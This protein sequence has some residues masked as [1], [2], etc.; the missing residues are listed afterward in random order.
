MCLVLFPSSP[1]G[2][3]RGLV[4]SH[5]QATH[6]VC[7]AGLL[8][9]RAL[10]L[11]RVSPASRREPLVFPIMFSLVVFPFSHTWLHWAQTRVIEH[12]ASSLPRALSDLRQGVAA[13][14]LQAEDAAYDARVAF[15]ART[16]EQ[17]GTVAAGFPKLTRP[18]FGAGV[19][20]TGDR[21]RLKSVWCRALRSPSASAQSHHPGVSGDRCAG[22]Q[23]ARVAERCLWPLWEYKLSGGA[24]LAPHR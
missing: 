15:M 9:N 21:T 17:V 13:T 4:R 22:W 1:R 2:S 24:L 6:M 5:G 20:Q 23:L 19:R 10:L 8:A 3:S 7:R 18:A 11:P 12:R 16:L 14:P